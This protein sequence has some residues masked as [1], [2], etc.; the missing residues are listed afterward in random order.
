MDV[1]DYRW[2]WTAFLSGASI[3]GY[4]FIYAVYYFVAKTKMCVAHARARARV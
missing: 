4:V 3:A 2:P 1:Q